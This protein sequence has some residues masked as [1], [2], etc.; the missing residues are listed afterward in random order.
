MGYMTRERNRVATDRH[1]YFD[2]EPSICSLAECDVPHWFGQK[3]ENLDVPH[4]LP[5][6]HAT[7]LHNT[8]PKVTVVLQNGQ[9]GI[10]L[11]DP[12]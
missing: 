5:F 8:S 12:S 3:F 6:L 10:R 11:V 9:P 2:L 4:H 7:D 1:T